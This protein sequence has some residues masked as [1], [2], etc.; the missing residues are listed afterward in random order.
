MCK[1]IYILYVYKSACMKI[2]QIK[3]FAPSKPIN[4]D[5]EQYLILQALQKPPSYLISMTISHKT[6]HE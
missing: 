6:F 3:K 1:N 5:T 2:V 4:Q